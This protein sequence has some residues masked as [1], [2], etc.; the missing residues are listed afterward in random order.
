MFTDI[1][2][3]VLVLSDVSHIKPLSKDK[4]AERYAVFT[5]R[6]ELNV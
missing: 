5:K 6:Y 1:M 3:K 2:E 4:V